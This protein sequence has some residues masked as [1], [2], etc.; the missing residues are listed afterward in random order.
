MLKD[1]SLRSSED[2]RY[3]SE[4]PEA[5]REVT[6]R[7][8]RIE[9]YKDRA[10]EKEDKPEIIELK[11]KKLAAVISSAKHLII[12][13]GA[14]ISTAAKIPDYRGPKGIWTLL[15]KGEEIGDHDLSLADPTFTHMSIY[16][17]HKRNILKYV[18]SQ[19]GCF[20][21]MLTFK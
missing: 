14:G 21:L 8:E 7:K 16:E 3:L 10:L 1:E 4:H 6:S 15:Q 11:S 2:I 12:Y 18:V 13:S 5:M 19:V 20:T 9:K 17:L